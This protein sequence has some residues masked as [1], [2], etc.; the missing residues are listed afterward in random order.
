MSRDSEREAVQAFSNKSELEQVLTAGI[1]GAPE[2]KKDEKR[3]YL[4]VFREQVLAILSTKQIKETVLYSEIAQALEDK[5]SAKLII[6][7]GINNRFTKKYKLLARKLNKPYTVVSDPDYAQT[8]GLVVASDEAVDIEEVSIED[9]ALRL[10]NL[11]VPDTLIQSTGKK[12]CAECLQHILNIDPQ[13]KINY[14]ELTW[15]DR[16]TGEHCPAHAEDSSK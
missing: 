2:L 9:R 15:L 12:V 4:G 8:T 5:R 6:N 1:H 10:R 13:E 3:Q 16:I 7:G 11:G 14:D